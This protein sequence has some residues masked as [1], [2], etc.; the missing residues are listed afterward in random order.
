MTTLHSIFRGRLAPVAAGLV[1]L[2]Y[3]VVS[4]FRGIG[5]STMDWLGEARRLGR[6]FADAPSSALDWTHQTAGF[7]EV[8]AALFYALLPAGY[9]EW[10][11][12]GCALAA[13]AV[14]TALI[15]AIAQKLAGAV[16]GW[17]ALFFMLT[18]APWLGTFTRLDPTFAVIPLI[19]AVVLVWHAQ[20]W[21]WWLRT[22][23]CAPLLA[24]G[25]LL[26]PGMALVI[27]ILL[28]VELLIGPVQYSAAGRGL[29]AGPKLTVD[30]LVIPLAAL[31]LLLLYPLFWPAP[32]EQLGQYF[33]LAVETSPTQFVFR[34]DTYPPARPP[35][36]T[37]AAWVFEQ[38]PLAFVAALCA[39]ILWAFGGIDSPDQRLSTS[40]AA[41]AT[42]LMMTP[43]LFRT[44]RP[45]GIDFAVLVVATGIPVASLITCRFFSFALGR[46]APT[47]KVRHVAI[48][49]FVLAGISILIEVPR[50]L[51]SPESFRSPMSARLTG[52]SASGDMP[53]RQD[54]LPLKLIENSGADG[55][56][57][58]YTAGWERHLEVYERMGL[59]DDVAITA[60]PA[61][62][63]IAI[64]PVPAIA[65]DRF[66][67][68]QANHLSALDGAHTI[69]V[70][71]IHRPLFFIDRKPRGQ[72]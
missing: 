13:G 68:Y 53:M 59:L 17:M 27:A 57:P 41:L 65:A 66:S 48:G 70:P 56:T 3:M 35:I 54:L 7:L 19:L 43:V 12:F 58:L 21:T 8:F 30:R 55:D 10:V 63:D 52:W 61:D 50:A 1:A 9:V 44:P 38:L 4:G 47:K 37:G 71:D 29:F 6:E 69:V 2:A 24:C 49:T 64:R 15:F 34:G 62:A 18:C 51:E 14:G 5:A 33:A 40:C 28:A 45:M 36:Y 11:L 72:D 23:V 42:A 60:S 67:A 20:D 31:G 25:V 46:S 16:G 39:G 32:F 22:A 26:W